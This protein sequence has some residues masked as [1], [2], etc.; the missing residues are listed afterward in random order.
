MPPAASAVAQ[1]L[2][3]PGRTSLPRLAN[4]THQSPPVT[5]LRTAAPNGVA[6]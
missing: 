3:V 6:G 4:S 1:Q 2:L 5:R